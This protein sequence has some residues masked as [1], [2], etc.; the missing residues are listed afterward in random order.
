MDIDLNGREPIYVQLKTE[1]KRQI[2]LG[3][4]Q[5]DD[6][7]PTPRQLARDLGIN[8]NNVRKAY[9]EL[10][11]EGII[12]T[13]SGKGSFV[14]L[15]RESLEISDKTYWDRLEQTVSRLKSEGAADKL[16]LQKV[17]D[18]LR[19]WRQRNDRSKESD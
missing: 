2:R 8:P 1:F 11:E 4:L 6:Q 18:V 9:L 15:G 17:N 5:V 16:I 7:M 14:A 3:I 13:I 10:A 12:Y 19:T